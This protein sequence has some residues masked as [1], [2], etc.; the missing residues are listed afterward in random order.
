VAFAHLEGT[1]HC[2]DLGHGIAGTE[3]DF[4]CNQDGLPGL[5][6]IDSASEDWMEKGMGGIVGSYWGGHNAPS[7]VAGTHIVGK[8]ERW[9]L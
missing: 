6:N 3:D 1:G 2:L 7:V 8:V 4:Q 5:V 9:D